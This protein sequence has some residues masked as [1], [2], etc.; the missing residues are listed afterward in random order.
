MRKSHGVVCEEWLIAIGFHEFDQAFL[1]KIRTIVS[2]GV[3]P[4]FAIAVNHWLIKSG[5]LMP[6]KKIP[7]IKSQ[8][9][10]MQRIIAQKAQL[11]FT[12]DGRGI[13]G[14]LQVTRERLIL[15]FLGKI[16][17]CNFSMT[18]RILAR[19][20]SQSRRVTYRHAVGVI[21]FHTAACQFVE[22]RCGV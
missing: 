8:T 15:S 14:S 13:P 20:Q 9:T 16:S 11:P 19:H 10:R 7:L 5:S 3:Q 12:C 22:V 6:T 21:E 17:P 18:K 2:Q 1:I 4:Y